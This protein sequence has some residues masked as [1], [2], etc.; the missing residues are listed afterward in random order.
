MSNNFLVPGTDNVI[1]LR[2]YRTFKE[3]H[4]LLSGY[5]SRV[6]SMDKQQISE[7]NQ[8]IVEEFKRYPKHIL[9]IAKV[10]IFENATQ[11]KVK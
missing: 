11:L 8:R 10:Q 4:K 6:L 9:T 7:E 1:D 2:K 3:C 5:K